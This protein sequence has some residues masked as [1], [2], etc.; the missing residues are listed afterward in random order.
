MHT[1]GSRP[2]ALKSSIP[3]SSSI[4][5]SAAPQIQEYEPPPPTPFDPYPGYYELPNG[6]WAEYA[7]GVYKA[8]WKKWEEEY[9][10]SQRGREGKGW[11]G[12]DAEGM[13]SVNALEEMKKQQLAD[14]EKAKGLTAPPT[15]IAPV[16]EN[17]PVSLCGMD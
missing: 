2:S 11:E 1:T 14:R 6:T 13:Q 10:A 4:S 3:S 17:I 5:I 8:H 12:A 9:K 16:P 7:P 15:T